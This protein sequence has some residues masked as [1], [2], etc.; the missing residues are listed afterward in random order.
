[1]GIDQIAAIALG[2]I[3]LAGIGAVVYASMAGEG[4]GT[5]NA[6]IWFAVAALALV[7]AGLTA[8]CV[9]VPVASR[10]IM[11]AGVLAVILIGYNWHPQ[12]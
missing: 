7:A 10:V 3:V 5:P 8:L 4:G 9:M 11:P 6:R 2:Y 1:M 12:V